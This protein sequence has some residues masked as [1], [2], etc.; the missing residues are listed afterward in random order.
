MANVIASQVQELYVGYLGRAADQAGLDFWTNAIT[1]GTSTIESVALGFTQSQEYT[2]KYEGLSNEELA[3]AIYQNVLGRAADADGLAFWVGE[4]E[5]GVQTPETLL[6]A[7]INSLG[8]VD[9]K[10]IDNKVYVANAYTAAAGADYKVEAGAK[11][12]EGVDGTAAS[13][14]K[15]IGALPT[16]TETITL[17]E[18][19]AAEELPEE[20]TLSDATID[21]GALAVADVAAAQAA[22]AAVVAGATNAAELTLEATYT[23]SDSLEVIADEAN[24]EVVAG[25]ES[26][27]LSDATVDL[28]ALAVADVAAAQAAAA[29]VVAGATNAAELTLEATYTLSDSLEV[30]ADEAN[31]EVVA[32]A[33]SYTLSDAT[34]DLGALAVA[35]VAAAQAAAAAV[36]AGAANAAELELAATYTIADTLAN[37]LAADVAVLAA[38]GSYSLTDAAGALGELTEA[39]VAVV[40]GAANVADLTYT[41][42]FTLTEGLEA[43]QAATSAKAAF[44]E[45]NETTEAD[46]EDNLDARE[47]ELATAR[48]SVSDRVLNARLEDAQDAVA[49]ARANIDSVAGLTSAVATLEDAQDTLEAAQDTR[50]DAFAD[51]VGARA[52]FETRNADATVD[53]VGYEVTV[54]GA[55]VIELNDSGTLVVTEAGAEVD[56][57]NTLLAAHQALQAADADLASAGEAVVSAEGVIN[58]LD[59]TAAAVELQEARDEAQAELQAHVRANGSTEALET[60]LA[61]AQ[62]ALAES[63]ADSEAVTAAQAAV[64][65]AQA[66]V[67]TRAE[68]ESDVVVA[69]DALAA[70]VT[71]F[72]ATADLEQAVVDAQGAVEARDTL[73]TAVTTAQAAVDARADLVQDV[74]D[75][76]ALVDQR[77]ALQATVTELTDAQDARADLRTGVTNAEAAVADFFAEGNGAEFE[78]EAALTA[79]LGRVTDLQ[80]QYGELDAGEQAA[81]FAEGG[82]GAEFVD[83]AAMTDEVVRLEGLAAELE[84]LTDTLADAQAALQASID[85]Y[86]SDT[87]LT[88]DSAQAQLA[89]E[90]FDAE[91]GDVGQA[92]NE[93]E[94]ALQTDIDENGDDAALQAALTNAQNALIA[95][96]ATVSDEE[97]EQALLDAQALVDQRTELEGDLGA[98]QTA[99]ADDITANGET[100]VLETALVDAQEALDAAISE[101]DPELVAQVEALQATLAE[102]AELQAAADEAQAEFEDAA[103]DNPRVDALETALAVEEAAQD[104]VDARAELIADVET[105]QVL[106]DALEE[107][108]AGIEGAEE[109]IE[110]LGFE[111]PVTAE[112]NVFGTAGDDI[113]LFSGEDATISGFNATGDDGLYIG[114]GFTRA[115]LESDVD[116]VATREGSADTLEVF[117]QQDGNNAVLSFEEVAFAGNATGNFEGNVITL[118]GVNVDDLTLNAEGFVT[119]A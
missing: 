9:Q 64:E 4:L 21:L 76:Q 86:G 70:H 109:A 101:G 63:A 118:T 68:L 112:D 35:D 88:A 36:V 27:N 50:A 62:A 42:E 82:A 110:E 26:Y 65:A 105:A 56:G 89:L 32:G 113:F 97:L 20:Y 5:K 3:A 116:L 94:D 15:A 29:A 45:E 22:A 37:V 100:E 85:E 43:L 57:I 16:S 80:A 104:A 11:I 91:N 23:L 73:V 48:A 81:F 114:S 67:D 51:V 46:I 38:A 66:A 13:V 33:E 60:Q 74:A 58:E 28:G 6:A 12:L 106:A 92:L 31:A 75:A 54:D 49:A 18:A 59:L 19:I 14:A 99:L 61:D 79:E 108:N 24:A 119:I 2:S 111:L 90:T 41:V 72:G 107:L 115:D 117:F 83:A 78:D 55:L 95:A 77:D 10:V 69:E 52:N 40:L 30:I 96:R 34:V 98:A 103:A 7:M 44:L 53:Y 84:P 1:A 47:T 25:A 8:A 102:R 17:T 93:A 71:E 87:Q 39:Q